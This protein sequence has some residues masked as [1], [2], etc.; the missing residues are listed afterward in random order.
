MGFGVARIPYCGP[1]FWEQ[2]WTHAGVLGVPLMLLGCAAETVFGWL[3]VVWRGFGMVQERVWEE[4]GMVLMRF[5]D[6][7]GRLWG[8]IGFG[9][10]LEWF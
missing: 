1:N 2:V 9:M 3:A 5:R 4:S 6:D 8:R 7:V 10:A